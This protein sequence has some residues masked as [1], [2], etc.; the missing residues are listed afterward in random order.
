MVGRE[1]ENEDGLSIGTRLFGKALRGGENRWEERRSVCVGH[2]SPEVNIGGDG[3]EV[4]VKLEASILKTG[5]VA[6]L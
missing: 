2:L 6:H 5:V 4:S 1:T 3:A